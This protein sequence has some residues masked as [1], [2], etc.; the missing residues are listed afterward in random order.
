MFLQQIFSKF[1]LISLNQNRIRRL[2]T[3]KL[4]GSCKLLFRFEIALNLITTCNSLGLQLIIVSLRVSWI[5]RRSQWP[6]GLR[7]GSE[8][9]FLLG[10]RVRILPGAWISVCS[11]CCVLS[12]RGLFVGP[13]TRPE[14]SYRVWCVSECD[15][16]ASIMRRPWPTGGCRAM[17]GKKSGF[18]FGFCFS[19][20]LRVRHTGRRE[21]VS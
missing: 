19:Q 12:D 18:I 11:Q 10:L 16:E 3:E 8:A 17:G 4:R 1:A 2:K 6:R 14:E 13:I 20:L 7:R 9:A 5:Y 15:C 21:P